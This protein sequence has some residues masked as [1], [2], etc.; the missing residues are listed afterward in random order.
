MCYL[1]TWLEPTGNGRADKHQVFDTEDEAKDRGKILALA[2]A[3]D[4]AIWRQIATPTVETLVSWT[5]TAG[6]RTTTNS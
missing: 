2:G 4:I 5:E 6:N 1:V 3:G